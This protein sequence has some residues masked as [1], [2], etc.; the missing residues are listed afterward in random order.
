[1]HTAIVN[2]ICWDLYNMYIQD[3]HRKKCHGPYSSVRSST[4]HENGKNYM[5]V[6][7]KF[8]AI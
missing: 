1:M 4:I 7:N 3:L 8:G 5:Y 2:M 6:P